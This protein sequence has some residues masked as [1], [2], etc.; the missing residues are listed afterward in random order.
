MSF[1][2]YHLTFEQVWD[3]IEELGLYLMHDMRQCVTSSHLIILE[4]TNMIKH[5]LP[6][7]SGTLQGRQ[8]NDPSDPINAMKTAYDLVHDNDGYHPDLRRLPVLNVR[9]R[10]GYHTPGHL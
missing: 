1:I 2:Q 5:R 3:R 9:L 7:S 4:E 6:S 8:P 10:G